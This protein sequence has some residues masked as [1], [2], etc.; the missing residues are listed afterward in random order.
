M[1]GKLTGRFDGTTPDGTA[2]INVHGVGYAVRVPVGSLLDLKA[3]SGEISLYIHTAVRDDAIDLYG[4]TATEELIFFK[5]LMSVSGIGPKTAINILNVADVTT[6]KNSVARGDSTALTKVF[7]IGKKSAERIVVELRDKLAQEVGTAG[8]GIPAGDDGEVLEAL[9]SLGY[10]ADESR[11]VL[12]EIGPAKE[13]S[14]RERIAQALKHL[15]SR[16]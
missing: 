6:L 15:G 8:I 7:G 9:M 2:L 11:K 13:F 4:F 1:I 16:M 5:Q 10:K 14:T 12:K 3:A